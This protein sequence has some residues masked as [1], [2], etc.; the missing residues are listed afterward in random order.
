[1]GG[2]NIVDA[3]R[4]LYSCSW[5]SKKWWHRL[6]Y[7]CVDITIVN[8]HIIE[9]CTPHCEKRTQLQFWL[10]LARELMSAYS[11][12]S[13]VGRSPHE[14]PVSSRYKERHFPAKLK[15]LKQCII[16]HLSRERKHSKFTCA[17]CNPAEPTALCITPC[18][19]I[20]HTKSKKVWP[21]LTDVVAITLYNFVKLMHILA[22]FNSFG[23]LYPFYT[24]S[25]IVQTLYT[26]TS[27][28][29]YR[30]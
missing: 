22:F 28:I 18:F 8:A 30:R 11:C 13:T 9:S 14:P 17:Y 25:Y 27:C 5:C 6:F 29:Q 16:C 10:E 19:K 26:Y 4:K 2:V 23:C 15:T 24:V 21:S 3:K 7:F 12:R 1:M 20:Y